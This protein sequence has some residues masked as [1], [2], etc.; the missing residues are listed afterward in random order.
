LNNINQLLNRIE[1]LEEKVC[2]LEQTI[3]R[4]SATFLLGPRYPYWHMLITLGI[5]ES[6]LAFG[7][8]SYEQCLSSFRYT[9]TPEMAKA[10]NSLNI[11]SRRI[12]TL[13][14]FQKRDYKVR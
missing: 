6:G 1:L 3:R 13:G 12:K 4:F 11:Q 2:S 14:S 8:T 5:S 10:F 7:S 9:S